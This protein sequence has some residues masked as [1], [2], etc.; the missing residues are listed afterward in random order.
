[1]ETGKT[2]GSENS[3]N[4]E[5]TGRCRVRWHLLVGA[6]DRWSEKMM[7]NKMSGRGLDSSGT[8]KLLDRLDAKQ[9]SG[10]SSP[11][12]VD[13]PSFSLSFPQGLVGGAWTGT[14]LKSRC[15][16]IPGFPQWA[17]PTGPPICSGSSVFFL[18]RVYP[19][20]L[21]AFQRTTMFLSHGTYRETPS[22]DTH[23]LTKASRIWAR[24]QGGASH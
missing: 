17:G 11:W 22:S 24:G 6:W 9:D 7:G 1:M 14:V 15:Q 13:H 18:G 21:R 16:L 8:G 23:P 2:N 19:T 20:V 3:P 10:V 5:K 12:P 4:P